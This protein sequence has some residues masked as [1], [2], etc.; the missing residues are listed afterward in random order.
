MPIDRRQARFGAVSRQLGQSSQAVFAGGKADWSKLQTAF[1][2]VR[3]LGGGEALAWTAQAAVAVTA[4]AVVAYV[5]RSRAA[6]EIK[7][8]ALGT[9]A[10][11][12]TPYL[13]TY[14]LEVL[15]VAL[16]F[17]FRLGRTQGF[18]ANEL[19]AI[20]VACLLIL[21]F[22]LPFVKVQVGLVAVVIVAALIARRALAPR[23]LS[24]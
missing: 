3:T 1:G 18:L 24:A 13:Y 6:Y 21:S 7:A 22:I 5:W 10:M 20:G 11:L 12:A 14:D 2:L 23:S 9:G 19:A 17:L 8:A 4:A 15:A 16:A